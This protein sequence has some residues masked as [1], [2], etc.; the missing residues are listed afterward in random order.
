MHETVQA[1]FAALE[2]A[3]RTT[4][5]PADR[6]QFIATAIEKLPDLYRQ[7]RQTNESRF[8]DEITRLVQAVLKQ[9]EACPKAQKLDA[10]FREGLR[11]LHEDLGIPSLP[12]RPVAPPPKPPKTRKK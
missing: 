6:K 8:G 3:V 11:V 5:I 9:L 2:K 10:D 1:H 7:Y 4:A 12:L